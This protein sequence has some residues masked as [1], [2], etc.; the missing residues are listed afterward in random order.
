MKIG[1]QTWGSRGDVM[2]FFGLANGLQTDGHDV[3]LTVTDRDNNNYSA[4]AAQL[5]IKLIHVYDNLVNVPEDIFKEMSTARNGVSN[6][7]E[8]IN[9]RFP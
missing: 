4:L 1:M 8:R 6:T 3:T 2:P 9:K 5:G 7:V